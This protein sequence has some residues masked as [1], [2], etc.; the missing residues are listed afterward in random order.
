MTA[1]THA[2]ACFSNKRL[3]L[4]ITRLSYK[5]FAQGY[6]RSGY[7]FNNIKLPSQECK[8]YTILYNGVFYLSAF[9]PTRDRVTELILSPNSTILPDQGDF[10]I[11]NLD[12][13]YMPTEDV[14]SFEH[15]NPSHFGP[16]YVVVETSLFQ[17]GLLLTLVFD[18]H[19]YF[20]YSSKGNRH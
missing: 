16:A 3:I 10:Q 14:F 8:R 4:R 2:R 17:N 18:I 6:G 5:L 20:L 7:L 13:C 19:C 9:A 11:D 12:G 1:H 15:L